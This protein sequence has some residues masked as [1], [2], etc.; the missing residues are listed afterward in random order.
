MATESKGVFRSAG[1]VFGKKQ[2]FFNICQIGLFD[3]D[4]EFV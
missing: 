1:N 2:R 3:F 4:G